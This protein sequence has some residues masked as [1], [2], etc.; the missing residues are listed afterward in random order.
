M[1]SHSSRA[2]CLGSAGSQSRAKRGMVV[3]F[4]HTP[5]PA[6]YRTK[7]MVEHDRELNEREAADL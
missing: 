4:G 5:Y 6:D 2:T 1:R 7:A 3:G